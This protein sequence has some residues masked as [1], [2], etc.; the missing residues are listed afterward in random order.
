MNFSSLDTRIDNTIYS[1]LRLGFIWASKISLITIMLVTIVI[2]IDFTH[3]ANTNL[4]LT[5]INFGIQALLFSLGW[6]FFARKKTLQ[7][8][9]IMSSIYAFLF[10]ITW[11]AAIINLNNL[12]H[13]YVIVEIVGN[14]LFLVVLLGFYTYRVAVYL[15]T[16]PILIFTTWYSIQ[17]PRFDLLFAFAKLIIT[18]IIIESGRRLLFEWFTTRIQQEHHNKRLLKQLTQ[19]SFTDQLTQINN[20]RFFDLAINKQIINA[21]HS[22]HPLSII[23]IDI[24]YFKLF[25]DKLGHVQGD[26]CLK[27]VANIISKSLLTATDTVSRYGGE[28]FVVLLPNTDNKGACNVAQRIQQNLSRL[29]I[30][31]PCSTIRPYVTV[32]QGIATLEANQHPTQLINTADN[33]LYKAKELGRNQFYSAQ[34]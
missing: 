29:A 9:K 28:E 32:S 7:H 17:D 27:S 34:K 18:I 3:T 15:A 12:G 8:Y 5:T 13:A 21:K 19:L 33:Y 23:L 22:Q 14:L 4:V 11:G 20:R 24:D 10:G 30:I 2:W 6:L 1:N 25:N 16:L 31:H 26:S